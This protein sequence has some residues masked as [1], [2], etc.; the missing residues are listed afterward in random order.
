MEAFIQKNR[1]LLK[2]YCLAAK[3]IGWV[4]IWGGILWFGLFTLC[5]LAASDAAGEM[6][7]PYTTENATYATTAFVF[8]FVFLGLVALVL[9][10]LAYCLIQD[11]YKPGRLLR[12]GQVIFYV[13]AGLVI[14]NAILTYHL[15]QI[16]VPASSGAGHLLFAQPLVFPTLAKAAI[17][18][19]AGVILGRLLP[20]IEESKTLV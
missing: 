13:Y 15:W 19:G 12:Y 6:R 16:G 7:W 17:L 20:V 9:S 5:I 2:F 11:E 3:V 1:R 18:I 4:L 14:G 10:Q 8:D